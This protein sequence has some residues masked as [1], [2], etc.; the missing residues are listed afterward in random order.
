MNVLISRASNSDPSVA[1]TAAGAGVPQLP[2]ASAPPGQSQFLSSSTSSAGGLEVPKTPRTPAPPPLTLRPVSTA[3]SASFA[4]FLGDGGQSQ[5][6]SQSPKLGSMQEEEEDEPGPGS[7]PGPRVGYP[8][9]APASTTTSPI[10]RSSPPRASSAAAHQRQRT[11]SADEVIASLQAQIASSK[12]A[13]ARRVEELEC[14]VDGLRKEVGRLEGLVRNDS[15][16]CDRCGG[17]L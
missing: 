6:Q 10:L 7:G 9:S 1:A 5:S 3:F 12:R 16:V 11:Q 14:E 13:W 17:R 2:L 8:K 15:H 4:G